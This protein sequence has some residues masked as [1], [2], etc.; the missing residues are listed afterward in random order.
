MRFF[1][2]GYQWWQSQIVNS[3]TLVSVILLECARNQHS[4][5]EENNVI[6]H[7]MTLCYILL[8]YFSIYTVLCK[9]LRMFDCM[10]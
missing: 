3:A 5:T 7:C 10:R 8:V 2:R 4:L 6:L 1:R 9:L